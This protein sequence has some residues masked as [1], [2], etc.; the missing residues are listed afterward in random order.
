MQRNTERHNQFMKN[1]FGIESTVPMK[2]EVEKAKTTTTDTKELVEE[3]EH[4]VKVLRSVSHDDDE[5]EADKQEKELK[6][7]KKQLTKSNVYD[8]Q[9]SQGTYLKGMNETFEKGGFGSGRHRLS[10]LNEK[11]NKELGKTKSGK[12]VYSHSNAMDYTDFTI[13]DHKDAI[14][15][16]MKEYDNPAN[17]D[18]LGNKKRHLVIAQTHANAA[19]I[20]N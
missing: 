7:Y 18:L 9:I 1:I 3:H 2:D 20:L 15:H 13:Q 5:K 8:R 10:V 19:G 16:H 12:P 6:G 17:D 11:E 4:L 14:R